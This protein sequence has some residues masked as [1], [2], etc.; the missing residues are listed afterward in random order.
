[1]KDEA[2]YSARDW[3]VVDYDVFRLPGTS[4]CFRGPEPASLEPGTY[5]ACLGAAQTFGR[6]CERPFPAL[7][8][9]R[10]GIPALNLGTGGAG[11]RF[12]RRDERLME[13]VGAAR[14][15]IVQVM[16]GRSASNSLFE[17]EGGEVL[18]RRSDGARRSAV[19]AWKEILAAR[20]RV[21]L[22]LGGDRELFLLPSD[23]AGVRRL[24]EETRRDWLEQTIGLLEEIPAP[25]ILLYFS[26]RRPAYRELGSSVRTLFGD[27]PQLVNAGMVEEVARH[28]DAYVECVSRR[29]RRQRLVDRFTGRPT[30]VEMARSAADRAAPWKRNWYYP[31]PEMHQ[32]AA[33]LLEP[34]CRALLGRPAGSAARSEPGAAS[35]TGPRRPLR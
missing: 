10:L 14:F 34:A 32:E 3:R 35:P 20:S 26:R 30:A 7:L 12:Y 5:F 18:T 8:Q 9:E 6:F 33:S 29:G 15:A 19:A 13:V 17:S 23:A 24:V 28:A 21:R 16:S 22:P 4:L 27:F 1:M 11:P 31:S 2:G 25:V